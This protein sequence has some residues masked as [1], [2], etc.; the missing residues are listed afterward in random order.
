MPCSSGMASSWCQAGPLLTASQIPTDRLDCSLP[1]L[2]PLRCPFE[3]QPPGRAQVTIMHWFPQAAGHP[4]ALAAASSVDAMPLEGMAP[5]PGLLRS[6]GE[7]HKVQAPHECWAASHAVCSSTVAAAERPTLYRQQL[8]RWNPTP[9]V[10]GACCKLPDGHLG[11]ICGCLTAALQVV[12]TGPRSLMAGGLQAR[13][14]QR[15]QKD[16]C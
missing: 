14:V 11:G 8:R 5:W 16:G 4:L 1:L 10:T 7:G 9:L 15:Q 12:G 2:G 13:A 3:W 6:R